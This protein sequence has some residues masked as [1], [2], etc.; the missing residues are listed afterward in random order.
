LQIKAIRDYAQHSLKAVGGIPF[1]LTLRTS[2]PL[3][4]AYLFPVPDGAYTFKAEVLQPF[5]SYTATED[6]GLPPEFEDP[7]TYQLAVRLGPEYGGV[8]QD[9]A[10]L[11]ADMLRLLKRQYAK[12]V[13]AVSSSPFY[14]RR[15]DD[16]D[17]GF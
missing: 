3:A 12:P 14:A 1:E 11:A 5:S 8:P 10:A 2:Y 6:M 9:V 13:P 4:T 15:Y 17:G 16:I 7:I